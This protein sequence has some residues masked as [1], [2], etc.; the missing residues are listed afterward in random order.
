MAMVARIAEHSTRTRL[1]RAR[2]RTRK[3]A[4]GLVEIEEYLG[5]AVMLACFVVP[6]CMAA[7]SAG[8]QIASDIEDS[9]DVT[10]T[11]RK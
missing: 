6:M 1:C 2:A 10:L 9:H 4:G 5:T 8:Q 11:Q 7:R 3:R